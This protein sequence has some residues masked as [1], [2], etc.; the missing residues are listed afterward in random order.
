MDTWRDNE[1]PLLSDAHAKHALFPA[2]DDLT[3]TNLKERRLIEP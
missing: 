2:L 1:S 3:N